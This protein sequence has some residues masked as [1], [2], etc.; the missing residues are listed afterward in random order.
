MWWRE[1]TSK[2][3][4]WV[5]SCSSVNWNLS[6]GRAVRLNSKQP[7]RIHL[8]ESIFATFRFPQFT[9]FQI[10]DVRYVDKIKQRAE[11]KTLEK[12]NL[13][14][15]CIWNNTPAPFFFFP[16]SPITLPLASAGTATSV[17]LQLIQNQHLLMNLNDRSFSAIGNYIFWDYSK[18]HQW[19]RF[20]FKT[21]LLNSSNFETLL[22][23]LEIDEWMWR[24]KK[25]GLKIRIWNSNGSLFK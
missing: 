16:S 17:T 4:L 7:L 3:F 2:R 21:Q 15:S 18:T 23:K 14:L 9:T 25:R 8:F 20:N 6:V 1:C 10:I 11:I 12:T 5:W 24:L 13:L 19:N 22:S